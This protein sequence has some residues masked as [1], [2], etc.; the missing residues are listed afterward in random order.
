MQRML[1]ITWMAHDSMDVSWRY[2][3]LKETGRVSPQHFMHYQMFD[4]L[5]LITA[6]QQM[7]HK[8][9]TGDGDG[10]RGAR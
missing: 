4:Y 3:M 10:Y 9:G 8:E 7:K 2:N 6:P 1:C 5:S